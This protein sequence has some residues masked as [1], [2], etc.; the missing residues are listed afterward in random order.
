MI[1]D[2]ELLRTLSDDVN[3]LVTR[4]LN[5][6]YVAAFGIDG[7]GKYGTDDQGHRY[8]IQFTTVTINELSDSDKPEGFLLVLLS[9]YDAQRQGHVF[10]DENLRISLNALFT[11]EFIDPTCW[12]WGTQEEQGQDFFVLRLDVNKLLDW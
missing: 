6:K 10:T 8:Q 9:G 4:A 5:G 11:N 7:N 2:R 12:A 3:T 1:I